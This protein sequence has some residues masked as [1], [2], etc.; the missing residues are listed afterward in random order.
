MSITA[1]VHNGIVA[2][3][4]GLNVPD[5]TEV[6]IVLPTNGAHGATPAG[7][8]VRL[9]TFNGGGLLPGVNLDDGR[10]YRSRLDEPGK[11]SQLS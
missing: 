7:G 11:L 6:E 4:P 3:P 9:P 5:G 1:T 10:S 2:L 8:P